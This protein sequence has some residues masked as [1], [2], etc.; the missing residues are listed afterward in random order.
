MKRDRVG[1]TDGVTSL[2]RGFAFIAARRSTWA[3]A[4]VPVLVFTL[5]ALVLGWFAVV[6]IGPWLGNLVVPEAESALGT[7]IKIGVRWLGSALSGYVGLLLAAL[8][9]PPLSAPA[10][11]AL[12]RQQETALGMPPRP[13]HG[14]WRELV[15]GFSA[16][17]LALGV[18]VPLLGVLW[19]TALLAPALSPFV[20]VFKGLVVAAAVAWN[21]FDY[22]LTLRGVSA[23]ERTAIVRRYSG[24]TFGFGLAFAALFWIPCAGIV[25]LPVGVVAAARLTATMVG[26]EPTSRARA[27][28][29]IT[30]PAAQ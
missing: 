16:Q 2:G 14:F 11:E 25:L 19:I 24:A 15:T 13:S 1:F 17:L 30:P 7:G 8:L 12:V 22:P 4:A 21:L 27:E 3:L 29:P 9:A 6:H 5:L 18:T 23:S 20:L 10:L 28:S 26:R